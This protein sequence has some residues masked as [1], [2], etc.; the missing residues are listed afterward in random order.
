MRGIAE[1]AAHCATSCFA[2]YDL[3][4]AFVEQLKG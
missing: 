4:A 3:F 2:D 1:D